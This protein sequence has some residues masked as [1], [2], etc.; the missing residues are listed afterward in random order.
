MRRLA[1]AP[2]FRMEPAGY[3][4]NDVKSD[5]YKMRRLF[6]AFLEIQSFLHEALGLDFP[7]K[8]P[9]GGEPGLGFAPASQ[10]AVWW[11]LGMLTSK[12]CIESL[13]DEIKARVSRPWPWLTFVL[14]PSATWTSPYLLFLGEVCGPGAPGDACL[15]RLAVYAF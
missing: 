4:F 15:A 1:I 13:L 7:G 6:V 9:S 14:S 3:I 2:D 8:L 5:P 11:E 12:P 10:V